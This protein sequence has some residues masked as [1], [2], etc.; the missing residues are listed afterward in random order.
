MTYTQ[1]A[2]KHYGVPE[3]EL[4]GPARR[5]AELTD[6]V[7]IVVMQLDHQHPQGEHSATVQWHSEDSTEAGVYRTLREAQRAAYGMVVDD[8][9]E[10]LAAYDRQDEWERH[11]A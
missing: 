6:G 11:N 3:W 5:Q 8:F 1:E 2:R 7:I 4:V 9:A 10:Y